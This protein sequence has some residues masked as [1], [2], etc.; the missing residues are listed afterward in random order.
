MPEYLR[1][2]VSGEIKKLAPVIGQ[3]SALKLEQAYLLGD[4]DAKKKVINVLETIKAAVFSDKLLKGS[5]L[6][7]PPPKELS[8][9]L[10]KNG[11]L[12]VGDALYGKKKMYPYFMDK[13]TLLTHIG[14]FGSSGYGKTNA[15]HHL[16][17]NLI[18]QDLP[19]LIFDFSKRNY[20]DLMNIPELRG[21][22][23]VFTVGRNISPFKFNPLRPPAGVEISQWAKEF[24]EIFD[25]A[26]WLLGGGKHIILKMLDA[27]Y[28]KPSPFKFPRLVGIKYLLEEL[29]SAKNA[30][31]ERNWIVTAQRPIESLCFRETGKI[32]ETD[33]GNIPS[34]FFESPKITVLELDSLSTNDKTFFIEITLQWIRD[35]LIVKNAKETLSGVIVLEEAHHVLNREKSKRLG[36]ESVIDLVFREIRE[37]GIGMIYVDQHP[38]LISYPALGNTSTH[39]YMNLGL[40]TQHS[41][42]IQDASSMLGI[43]YKAEGKYLRELPIGHAFAL[44]RNSAFPH[45]FLMGF[46]IAR[47][48]KGSVADHD[49]KKPASC[50]D[51]AK[52]SAGCNTERSTE[53]NN[54]GNTECDTECNIVC[55]A[56]GSTKI[57]SENHGGYNA[58]HGADIE[59]DE[60]DAG[61]KA[62]CS[63]AAGED[64]GNDEE[65]GAIAAA[66]ASLLAM[67]PSRNTAPKKAAGRNAEIADLPEGCWKILRVLGRFDASA[68]SEIYRQVNMSGT[69]FK[70]NAEI[71]EKQGMLGF[72]KAKVYRQNAVFYFLTQKG[73][74]AF[75]SKFSAIGEDID[76]NSFLSRA[77]KFF[78]GNG[79]TIDRDKSVWILSKKEKKVLLAPVSALGRAEIEQFICVDG[80]HFLAASERSKNAIIQIS[81]KKAGENAA[82]N[83]ENA[84]TAENASSEHMAHIFSL[85]VASIGALESGEKFRKIIFSGT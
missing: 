75:E 67:P 53:C 60:S 48:K 61:N 43:D 16:A 41:S 13:K 10:S 3:E 1:F 30:A 57:D 19:V 35:W 23:N 49:L 66:K 78:T 32:F 74:D 34:D 17:R 7:E 76:E 38:S 51:D 31:R 50:G 40:D 42:D 59:I 9:E 44:F 65:R 68:T 85:S 79:W 2:D 73:A 33:K 21:R 25:H 11:G 22:V 62:E 70:K 14:I 4:D 64:G 12:Y 45:P 20:R 58:N 47:V 39:I 24:A 18:G 82:E 55:D 63:G 77:E 56:E 8:D 29:E 84:E 5:A 27:V 52:D 71:L 72:S 15:V 83:A 36:S 37:L 81:A 26:Y 54:G 69:S 46:P 28:R 80:A 6:M